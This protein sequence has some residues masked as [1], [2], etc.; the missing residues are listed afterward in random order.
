MKIFLSWSGNLSL[1]IAQILKAWIPS[2]LPNVEA[3]LS[4]EDIPKGSRWAYVLAERLEE[5]SYGIVIVVPGNI[6][7]PWLN[8]EIGAISKSL[9]EAR[10]S[11]FVFGLTKAE[12]TGPLSQFQAT[13]FE[14]PDV[15]QLI[16]SMNESLGSEAHAVNTLRERFDTHW[17]DLEDR[18]IGLLP[19]GAQE[20]EIAFSEELIEDYSIKLH[21]ADAPGFSHAFGVNV[22]DTHSMNGSAWYAGTEMPCPIHLIYGPY[23]GLPDDGDYWA[24]FRVKVDNNTDTSDVLHLDV[25]SNNNP[26]MNSYK[27]LRCSQFKTAGIYQF[28]GVRF[29]YYGEI[30]VEYR[31][32]KLAQQRQIWVDYI[33]V[34]RHMD[35]FPDTK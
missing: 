19:E 8:F 35:L 12:L 6:S 32:I 1:N 11:P 15:W 33:A 2:V 14:M 10:V 30:D 16:L 23:E 24:I 5:S 4:S 26:R 13:V 34:I 17:P 7:S 18:L 29:Q 27:K 9:S 21:Y 22:S 28:F 31:V 3:W 20:V 25:I